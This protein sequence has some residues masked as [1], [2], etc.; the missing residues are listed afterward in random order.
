MRDL[1]ESRLPDWMDAQWW[2]GPEEL[3]ALAPRAE[4]GWFDMFDKTVPLQAL[5]AAQ[6]LR[7][8]HT[9]F[10]GVDWMP[11]DNLQRRGVV[12]STGSGNNANPVAEF[13]VM[14]M[15][16][17][18]RGYREIVR[19]QQNA[20]WI[21]DSPGTR[22]LQGS[23]AIIIGAGAIGRRIAEILTGFGVNVRM[24]RRSPGEGELGP[25][26]WRGALGSADWLV[27][28]VPNTPDTRGMIGENELAAMNAGAVLVNVARAECVDQDA[29]VRALEAK[30]IGGAVLDLT[31]PEPLPPDHKLW[32]LDNAHVTMHLAGLPS[33]ATRRRSADRFL[34]NCE[35]WHAGEGLDARVDYARG[36]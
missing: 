26:E 7:W 10:A 17:V 11:L 6:G 36:Y 23:T 1:L 18:A 15:L 32:S 21:I 3:L 35:L 25:D 22:E 14:T 16:G 30:A 13:A 19:R 20:E 27:L 24:V 31:D 29:L 2:S 33:E 34:R 12:L 5:A 9:G 28:A 4:I 8:L